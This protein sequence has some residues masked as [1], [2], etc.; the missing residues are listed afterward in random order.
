MLCISLL[1][2]TTSTALISLN[3]LTSVIPL[4]NI[5]PLS[6]DPPILNPQNGHYYQ[7]VTEPCITWTEAKA[8][9]ENSTYNGV[10]G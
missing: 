7:Y 2:Q 4:S 6:A 10:S 9:A 3:I 8:A 5:P 1:K